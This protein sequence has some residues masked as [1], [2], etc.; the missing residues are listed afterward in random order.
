ML[1]TVGQHHAE[2]GQQRPDAVD[3]GRALLD[4]P[5]RTRC[6][7]RTA[8]C[9]GLLIGTNLMLG[10]VTALQIASA[11]LPSFLP[12]FLYGAT[13]TGAISRTVCPSSWN[14][15]AHSCAPEHASMPIRHGG[16]AATVCI[17]CSR[18]TVFLRPTRPAPS[19]PCSA[20]TRFA[21]SIP[22][23]V[24]FSMTSPLVIRLNLQTQ[25]WHF[26][27]VRANTRFE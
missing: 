26:D 2:L 19:T 8:C 7:D 20:N 25:S 10:R 27:A 22:A 6:S 24:I 5:W 17:S 3:R 11:S 14:R 13:S 23:V 1:G 12:L 15:R 16:K 21:K 9:S 4:P 18:L